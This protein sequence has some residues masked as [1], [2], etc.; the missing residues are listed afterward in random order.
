MNTV[1]RP[2]SWDVHDKTPRVAPHGAGDLLSARPQGAPKQSGE[3]IVAENNIVERH[4][5]TRACPS[6]FVINIHLKVRY[7]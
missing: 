4:P 5:D 6:K 2:V 7:V 1:R 3:V